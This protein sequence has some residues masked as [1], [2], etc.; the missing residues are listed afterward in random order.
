VV[1]AG[2]HILTDRK[3]KTK[4]EPRSAFVAYDH[5]DDLGHAHT[6]H[7]ADR[8]VR[9]S[10]KQGKLSRRLAMRQVTRLDPLSAHQTQVLTT[11]DD[12]AATE[13]AQRT[14]D[15]WR[16]ENFFRYMRPHFALDALDPYAKVP[17][18]PTRTV[19]GPA[20]VKAKAAT[21]KA[22]ACQGE[23]EKALA[24]AVAAAAD[25]ASGSPAEATAAINNAAAALEVARASTD[26]AEE[27]ARAVPARVPLGD[28][29]PDAV[30]AHPDRRRRL[31][32]A[33][34]AC[35]NLSPM[36]GSVARQRAR[37]PARSSSPQPA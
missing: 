24:D 37:R 5:V 8:A 13:V 21:K 7:L 11:H 19:P 2:S 35:W 6:Y 1:A 29:R 4:P 32:Q 16:I 27:H 10:Y 9:L 31:S 23:A 18:D 25:P 14:F 33:E 28:V 15:R 12:W 3:G 22:R 36:P 34:L 26:R 30:L 17:D 20:K